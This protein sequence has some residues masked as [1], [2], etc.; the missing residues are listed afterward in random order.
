MTSLPLDT[1]RLVN[2]LKD[3]GFNEQQAA[4]V[5]EAIQEI[6]LTHVATKSDLR[7]IELR[8]TIKLG[9]L[10]VAGT[11]FLAILKLFG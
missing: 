2:A 11:A 5:T 8:M 7:E 9:S 10:I 6:D 3:R 1:H 4:A